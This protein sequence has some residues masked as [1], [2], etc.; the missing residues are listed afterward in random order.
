MMDIRKEDLCLR[1]VT[2]SDIPQIMEIELE[3]FADPWSPEIFQEELEN[4]NIF[5]KEINGISFSCKH[6]Y[7]LEYQEQVL[8][9]V[10]GWAI[11]DEYSIMNIGVRKKYQKQGLG[12]FLLSKVIEKAIELECFTIY[13]DVRKSNFPAIKLYE[14][15]KFEKIGLRKHYYQNPFEDAVV[16]KLD[17]ETTDKMMDS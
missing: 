15:F 3:L 11:C 10:L 16:M 8:G 2:K 14:K 9:F 7:L 12:S 1:K 5:T 17:L 4:S 13:L 6:N